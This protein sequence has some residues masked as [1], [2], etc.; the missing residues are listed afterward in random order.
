MD[1]PPS[2]KTRPCNECGAL[3]ANDWRCDDCRV[4]QHA[5]TAFWAVIAAAHPEIHSGDFDDSEMGE[6]C[7]E[8]IDEWISNNTPA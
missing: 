2:L 4:L 5:L 7:R 3:T 8:Y 6:Q 1:T